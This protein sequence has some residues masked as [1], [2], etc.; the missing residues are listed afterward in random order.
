M[1][2]L[3]LLLLNG[4]YSIYLRDAPSTNGPNDY[5]ILTLEVDNG[6]YGDDIPQLSIKCS[7]EEKDDILNLLGIGG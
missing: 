7:L 2:K 4:G 3:I 5:Y 6:K 1:K